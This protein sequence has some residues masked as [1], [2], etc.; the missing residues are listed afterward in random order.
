MF[1]GRMY[2]LEKIVHDYNNENIEQRS[3]KPA[4]VGGRLCV[5]CAE[6][7][8]PFYVSDLDEAAY[9]EAA[10]SIPY[11]EMLEH[12][13]FYKHSEMDETDEVLWFDKLSEQYNV[14]GYLAVIRFRSVEKLSNSLIYKKKMEELYGI[15][16]SNKEK[17]HQGKNKIYHKVRKR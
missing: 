1:I 11:P 13:D 5:Q 14:D 10:I 9:L 16:K 3:L 17:N 2:K 4:F 7:G 8:M 12:I 15:D 6:G